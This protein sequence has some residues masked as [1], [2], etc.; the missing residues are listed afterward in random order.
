MAHNEI[1]SFLVFASVLREAIPFRVVR[2]A[3]SSY[4]ATVRSRHIRYWLAVLAGMLLSLILPTGTALAV[5]VAPADVQFTQP[6]GTVIVATPFGDEWYS[7]YEH[8]GYTILLNRS[9]NYWVYAERVR[10][11]QLAP[12]QQRVGID[13]PPANL[14]QHLRDSQALRPET[15][16][17][18]RLGPEVWPG[19]AGTQKVLVILTDFTPSTSRAPPQ[20]SGTSSSSTVRRAL[21]ASGTSTTRLPSATLA[22]LPLPKRTA[23]STMG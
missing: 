13:K 2:T 8:Q 9:N 14:S 15:V 10:D 7:G 18:P 1:D 20:P 6:D 5:P 23:R 3:S 12:G 22:W 16:V 19:T 4:I 11:G 21:R 17:T